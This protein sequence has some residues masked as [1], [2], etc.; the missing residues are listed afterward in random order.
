MT[1]ARKT[2]HSV[3]LLLKDEAAT[4]NLA[5]QLAKIA[6]QGDLILLDGDL[7]A[8][9]STLARAFIRHKM[10]DPE[11][12]VP[13][14]TFLLVL[15]YESEAWRILHADL[16]RI[17]D[18][19]EVDELGLDDD[20]AA[21]VLVEWPARDPML[22]KRATIILN[23]EMDSVADGRRVDVI[24]PDDADRVAQLADALL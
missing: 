18:A 19:A 4:N 24:F 2:N 8:G 5:V 6:R 9:K 13:S 15:P 12:D 23:F 17:G 7:G 1:G 22:E 16:Y 11:L 3:R 21:I 10:A 14:P 20:P